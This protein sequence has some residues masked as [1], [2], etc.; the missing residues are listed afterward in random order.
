MLSLSLSLSSISHFICGN[1]MAG[2]FPGRMINRL[3]LYKSAY[4]KNSAPYSINDLILSKFQLPS[5]ISD[6][7]YWNAPISADK[8]LHFSM[9]PSYLQGDTVLDSSPNLSH[10]VNGIDATSTAN[11]IR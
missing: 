3:S 6:L 8:H 2:S 10:A 5:D 1:N 9:R 4:F 7:S 11:S